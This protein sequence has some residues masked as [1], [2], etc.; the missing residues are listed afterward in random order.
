VTTR[1]A[2]NVAATADALLAWL[3]TQTRVGATAAPAKS[4]G[5]LEEATSR[6]LDVPAMAPAVGRDI[7]V[8]QPVER[9]AAARRT[10]PMRLAHTDRLH[11]RL[12]IIGLADQL[13][14]FRR[15]AAGAGIIPWQIDLDRL[16]RMSFTYWWRPFSRAR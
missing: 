8:T 15:A 12:A 3:E 13:A 1:A 16:R 10:S 11:H 2:V 14:A 4:E 5:C 7:G 9:G 6:T